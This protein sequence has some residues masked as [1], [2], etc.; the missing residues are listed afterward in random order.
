[1]QAS[2]IFKILGALVVLL[3]VWQL[4]MHLLGLFFLA[5]M[6]IGFLVVAF[7]AFKFGFSMMHGAGK[8]DEQPKAIESRKVWESD[9]AACL[10]TREP[11]IADLAKAKEAAGAKELEDKGFVLQLNNNTRVSV[12]EDK[13]QEAVKV[14]ILD[15]R[16][17]GKVGW[18]CRSALVKD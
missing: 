13:Q 8:S 12:V 2:T 1:M 11:S 3:I 7:F 14:K 9:G 16:S 5:F 10:Y 15:G 17:Q 18:I 6:V 4:F